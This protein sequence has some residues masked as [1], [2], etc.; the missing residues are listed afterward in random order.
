MVQMLTGNSLT[1]RCGKNSQRPKMLRIGS[2]SLQVIHG[3][4]GTAESVSGWNLKKFLKNCHSIF[5]KLP[6]RR[7]DYLAANNLQSSHEEK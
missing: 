1:F 3:A 7:S 2:C 5:K 4:L 6:A